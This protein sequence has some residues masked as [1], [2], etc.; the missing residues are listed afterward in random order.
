VRDE[1]RRRIM[2]LKKHR[3]V[4]VGDRVTLVFENRDT[5]RFQIEEMLRAESITSDEG[6]AAELEVYNAL[7]P[8]AGRCR[9][10]CSS[11][12]R[13]SSRPRPSCIGSSASTST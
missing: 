3:R 10:R 12:S 9:R 5:L 7:M 13:A 4:T 8:D 6:I 1:F 2:E 11:R